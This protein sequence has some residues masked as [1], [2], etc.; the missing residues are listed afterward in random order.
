MCCGQQVQGWGGSG[1]TGVMC[2]DWQ[3]LAGRRWLCGAA[4][5]RLCSR[6]GRVSSK[7]T[8]RVRCSQPL[9]LAVASQGCL[10]PGFLCSLGIPPLIFAFVIHL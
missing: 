3:A 1:H 2:S 8:P 6:L 5:F 4:A 10:C 9:F 7:L